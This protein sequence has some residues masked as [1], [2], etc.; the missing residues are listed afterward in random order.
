VSSLRNQDVDLLAFQGDLSRPDTI[1]QLFEKTK[2][3]FGGVDLLV[4]NA[5]DLLRK[6]FL[7]PH[8]ELLEHQMATNIRGPYLCSF[9]AANIMRAGKGGNIVHISSVG[10]QRAHW[11]GFPYDVTKGAINTLTWAMAIDLAEYGI[12]V[13]AIGP[14]AIRT[15]RTPPDD[16]LRKQGILARIPMER[17]GLAQE[18][19]AAVAFLAS[20]EAGYITGQVIYV[21]GG[22]SAQLSPR[23]QGV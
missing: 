19:G 7:D 18:I 12:R 17:F 10:A 1:Q 8:E 6:R 9:H 21:D 2:T 3:V 14:G 4:N 13:N 20:P 22:L 5:A 16:Y 11:R 15:Y 23:G